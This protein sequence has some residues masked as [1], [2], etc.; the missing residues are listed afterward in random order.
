M[1]CMMPM[2]PASEIMGFLSFSSVRPPL[3]MRITARIQ[4]SATPKRCDA[5]LMRGAQRAISCAGFI[6]CSV[7]NSDGLE[8]ATLGWIAE[9][10][11]AGVRL[12]GMELGRALEAANNPAA[13]TGRYSSLAIIDHPV[14]RAGQ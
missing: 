14:F 12:D 13:S 5:S 9:I 3:S 7:A 4:S 2:A 11:A 8:I 6:A 10:D 1:I